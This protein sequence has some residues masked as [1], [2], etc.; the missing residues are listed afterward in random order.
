[1]PPDPSLEGAVKMAGEV[2][3]HSLVHVEMAQ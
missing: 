2:S 1:M 3:Q